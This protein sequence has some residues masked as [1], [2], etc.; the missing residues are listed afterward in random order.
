[1]G[2]GEA[3]RARIP[4]GYVVGAKAV[5]RAVR[6]QRPVLTVVIAADAPRTAT[7]P[8]RRLAAAVFAR[9]LPVAVGRFAVGQS[10]RESS[11]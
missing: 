9:R 3:A 10:P 4:A 6:E 8:V 7:E 1:M 11:Q 2:H 5:A